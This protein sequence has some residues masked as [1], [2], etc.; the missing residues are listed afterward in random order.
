MVKIT[1]SKFQRSCPEFMKEISSGVVGIVQAMNGRA[2]SSALRSVK[3]TLVE[4]EVGKHYE[5]GSSIASLTL[6]DGTVSKSISMRDIKGGGVKGMLELINKGQ[7]YVHYRYDY[8]EPMKV[9]KMEI[10]DV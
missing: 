2:A 4:A 10:A 7:N 8:N 5:K 9:F 1:G 6:D 3:L